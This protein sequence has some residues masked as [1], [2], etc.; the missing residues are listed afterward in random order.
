MFAPH[1][2]Q[3]EALSFIAADFMKA[4]KTARRNGGR[5]DHRFQGFERHP[6]L[7]Y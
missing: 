5:G 6:D 2:A 4:I 1:V 3:M 7:R